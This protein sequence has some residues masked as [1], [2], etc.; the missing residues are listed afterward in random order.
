MLMVI[1][2][3]SFCI[4]SMNGP[5]FAEGDESAEAVALDKTNSAHS[6]YLCARL[7]NLME[8]HV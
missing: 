8:I 3:R 1:V 6:K 2:Q 4:E 5:A 7:I